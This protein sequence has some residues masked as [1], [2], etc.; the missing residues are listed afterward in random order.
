MRA[1]LLILFCL[2]LATPPA[3]SQGLIELDAG[4]GLF[5]AI[6][7]KAKFGKTIQVGIAQGFIGK[8]AFQSSAEIY[9]RLG[10]RFAPEENH[11]FYIMNGVGGTFLSTGYQNHMLTIY[12]RIGWSLYFSDHTGLNLD[13]GPCLFRVKDTDGSMDWSVSPS[14]SIHLFFRFL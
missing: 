11:P 2:L 14:G 4:V 8:Y 3:R 10:S 6:S 1:F 5:E 7:F 9:Y 13:F 12:P